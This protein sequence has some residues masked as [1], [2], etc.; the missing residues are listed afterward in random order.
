MDVIHVPEF[1]RL[2]YV[3]VTVDTYSKF[4]WATAQ[5]G[6]KALHVCKH[7]TS[8]FAVMGV[9]EQPKPD[10]GPAYTSELVRKFLLM[11]NVQ[12]R[13]GMPNSPTGQAIVERSNQT[14]K[15]CL[16]KFNSISDPKERLHKTLFVVNLLCVFGDNNEPPV[17]IHNM[18]V[19]KAAP[20]VVM[21]VTYHDPKTGLWNGPANV[22]FSGRG[23]V[24][25]STP[26]GPLW[27]P[28][29]WTQAAT[30]TPTT[31]TANREEKE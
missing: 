2:R 18:C 20:E 19:A 30:A 31:E 27:V 25:V 23:Y 3:H 1:G 8:C 21:R 9:P 22:I 4:I 13:K 11:W 24:C 7:L 12:H 15:S 6:E 28:S 17:V 10:N 16:N 5:P 29:K 26:T 14:L